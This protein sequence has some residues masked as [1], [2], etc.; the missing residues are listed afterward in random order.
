M[1]TVKGKQDTVPGWKTT[2][3]LILYHAGKELK[4][5]ETLAADGDL[6]YKSQKQAWRK[7]GGGAKQISSG[8][9]VTGALTW[10]AFKDN[11]TRYAAKTMLMGA[12]E[13]SQTVK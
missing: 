12:G 5:G 1:K 13:M 9:S 7:G 8:N 10:Q 3:N 6:L 2:W 11:R 4:E